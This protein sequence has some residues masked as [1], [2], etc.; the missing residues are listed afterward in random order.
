[1]SWLK[2]EVA[3]ET[4][5]RRRSSCQ[6]GTESTLPAKVAVSLVEQLAEGRGKY[7]RIS[8]EAA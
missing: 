6:V 5:A 8:K 1:M 3:R 2:K 7:P 4:W